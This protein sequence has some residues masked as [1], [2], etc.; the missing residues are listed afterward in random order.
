MP[1]RKPVA[2]ASLQARSLFARRADRKVDQKIR[3]NSG[4]NRARIGPKSPPKASQEPSTGRVS[5]KSSRKRSKKGPKRPQGRPW[6]PT[7]A[8][9]ER[10]RPPKER[11]EGARGLAR[12]TSGEGKSTT[13]RW[14]K[15]KKSDLPKVLRDSALPTFQAR[16]PPQ[17]DPESAQNRPTSVP[18]APRAASSIDFGRSKEPQAASA[19]ELGRFGPPRAPPG[20]DCSVRPFVQSP[21]PF[22]QFE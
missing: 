4:P 5:L 16:R 3:P 17:I 13:S 10:P 7:R 6:G 14:Q 2:E 22:R 12:G 1:S 21:V 19:S 8:S 20:F 18:R 15:R 9:Q 11:P